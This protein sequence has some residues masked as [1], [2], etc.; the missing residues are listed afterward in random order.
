MQN[1]IHI[2]DALAFAIY[3]W[4]FPQGNWES[5]DYPQRVSR[6]LRKEFRT[7]TKFGNHVKKMVNLEHD[8]FVEVLY[9]VFN[10]WVAD[11]KG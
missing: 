7:P 11:R 8:E 1:D 6:L 4:T 5:P 9:N 10:L 2:N 3:G